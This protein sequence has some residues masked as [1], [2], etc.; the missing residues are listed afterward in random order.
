MYIRVLVQ[1]N[2]RKVVLVDIADDPDVRQIGNCKWVRHRQRLHTG[3]AGDLLVCNQSRHGCDNID[4]SGGVVQIGS[5]HSQ[6]L[7]R[8][9]KVHLGGV[10]G[11]LGNLEVL[12]GDSALIEQDFGAIK[13]H[14]GQLL[15]CD[16]FAVVGKGLR[17]ICASNSKKE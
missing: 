11:V 5:Q 1:T 17:D 16:R 2:L 15:A 6:V 10:L 13:L 7:G 9:V 8:R 3:R 14:L 12:G 4:N